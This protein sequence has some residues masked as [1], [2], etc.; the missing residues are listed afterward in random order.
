VVPLW[1]VGE[2]KSL[3]PVIVKLGLTDGMNTQ[4]A[5]GKLNQGD[6]IVIGLEFDPNRPAPSMSARPPGF[7]GVPMI[8]R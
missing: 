4:I 7:G 1:I 2:D 3:K 6:R 8:R 5:E